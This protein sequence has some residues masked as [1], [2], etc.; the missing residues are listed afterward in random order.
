MRLRPGR[1]SGTTLV[2]CA[3]IYPLVFLLVIG[4]VIGALGIF[5]F[6]QMAS[7]ARRATRYASVHGTDWARD[8]KNTPATA[9]DIYNNAIQPNMVGLDPNKL[10]YSVT[11]NQSN[12]PVQTLV[13]NNL[14][15]PTRSTVTVSLSYQWVPEALFGGITLRATSC[16]A[17][18]Y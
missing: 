3:V 9:Q 8:T 14:P 5:R 2:E 11:W 12:Q 15:T 16:D 18:S 6:Q 4:L 1:R 17:M 7:I 13:V 10:T